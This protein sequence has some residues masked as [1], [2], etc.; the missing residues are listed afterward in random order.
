M[1]GVT[2][3]FLIVLR[4]MLAPMH[5]ASQRYRSFRRCC[6]GCHK[7]ISRRTSDDPIEAISIF[8]LFLSRFRSRPSITRMSCHVYGKSFSLTIGICSPTKFCWKLWSLLFGGVFNSSSVASSPSAPCVTFFKSRATAYSATLP[9]LSLEFSL[10][11]SRIYVVCS[12][13]C[14]CSVRVIPQRL[15]SP[16]IFIFLIVFCLLSQ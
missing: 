9:I 8:L 13:I 15:F 16:W 7:S 1:S 12:P 5:R 2:G 3:L 10:T 6:R 14:R 4:A 11:F